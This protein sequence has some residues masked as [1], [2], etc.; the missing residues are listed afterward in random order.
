MNIPTKNI[1]PS[2]SNRAIRD[3]FKLMPKDQFYPQIEFLQNE[4]FQRDFYDKINIEPHV[5]TRYSRPHGL[6]QVRT[7]FSVA[8]LKKSYT[9]FKNWDC[10]QNQMQIQKGRRAI[11]RGSKLTASTIGM[12]RIKIK[13]SS[14]DLKKQPTEKNYCESQRK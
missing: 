12:N 1:V 5:V 10:I 7:S 3:D 2:T 6:A 9:N 11:L 14:K 4:L 8:N 13:D